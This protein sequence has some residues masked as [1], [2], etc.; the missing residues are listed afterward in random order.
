[1]QDVTDLQGATAVL[2]QDA[3]YLQ[4]ATVAML[5]DA[6]DVSRLDARADER[7]YVVV[8][9]FSQLSRVTRTRLVF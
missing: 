4:G 5:Q 2:M 9:K 8:Q 6:T 7:L 3:T 1:M